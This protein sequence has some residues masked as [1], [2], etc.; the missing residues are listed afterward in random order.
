[1]RLRQACA[2]QVLHDT[3]HAHE[4]RALDQE[5]RLR[6]GQLGGGGRQ[7]IDA[8]EMPG[9]RAEGMAGRLGQLAQ[10]QQMLDAA[11]AGIGADF[12]VE[13]AAFAAD[14]AH[15]AQHQH[16]RRAGGG[17]HVDRSLTESGLAL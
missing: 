4:A 7:R 2:D 13:L 9:A 6:C 1:M 14:L 15:V 17:Q 3:L 12:L 10:R 11:A 16:A 8:V 5:R